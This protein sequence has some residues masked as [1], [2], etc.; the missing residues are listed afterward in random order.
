MKITNAVAMR[1]TQQSWKSSI[2]FSDCCMSP[3]G[4]AC[5]KCKH[6]LLKTLSS[7]E[8][9]VNLQHPTSLSYGVSS[10]EQRL[11]FINWLNDLQADIVFL[12]ETISPKHLHMHL[13]FHNQTCFILQ[14]MCLR[15]A[16][17]CISK[18]RG[19]AIFINPLK[20]VRAGTL[21]FP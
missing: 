19:I 4:S 8:P 12:Q 7:S 13:P 3:W 21:C 16:L 11:K 17:F 1:E 18:Q 10:R 14:S 5:N 9:L 2:K 15:D 20:P 6:S